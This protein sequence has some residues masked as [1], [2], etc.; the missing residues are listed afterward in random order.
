MRRPRLLGV[1][2]SLRNAR[3]GVGN[4]DLVRD[5]ARLPDRE[6]LDAWLGEQAALHLENF[7]EAGRREG[8][9]F[10]EI[11]RNLRKL[12]GRVGLSNSEVALAAGLWAA[13][14]AGVEVDHLSLAEHFDGRSDVAALREK[15][16]VADGLLV[17][18]PVYFGDRGS[19]AE[20]F[21]ELIGRD[22]VLASALR[23]R[24]YG[25]IAVGAKRNGGQETTLVYQM[26]DMLELGMLAV[27]ND[28]ETTSQYGGT[29]HAGDVGTM[30]ADAYGLDTSIGTGRRLAHVM[31]GL[32]AAGSLADAPRALFLVL[33]D[34]D[35][36]AA[37]TVGDLV[38][39]LGDRMRPTV[40][41][42]TRQHVRRCIAC[43]ICPTHIGP[44][45]EYRCI[46]KS[47]RD[48][49]R[50]LHPTLLHHDLL[51]PVVVSS[52]DRS[53]VIS[54]YQTF[55]ERTRYLRRGDYA[56][57]DQ[58]V[59]PMVLEEIGTTSTYLSRMCTSFIRHHT[60]LTAPALG[61]VRAGRVLDIGHLADRLTAAVQQAAR[62][63]VARLASAEAEARQYN[64]VGYVLSAHKEM[65]DQRLDRRAEMVASR[66][67]RLEREAQER[68]VGGARGEGEV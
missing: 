57:S 45:E 10:I 40:L 2:A 50:E 6:S 63:A 48:D 55:V 39:R 17:S 65:E 21:I 36:L 1:A 37:R 62:L 3:W 9:D 20:S 42:L 16:A 14:Q 22:D 11:N 12:S 53:A 7:I 35:G 31:L 68:L 32:G 24:P 47:K 56:L 25:G 4:R 23:G 41:D 26:L 58:L 66:H 49:L 34:Q 28:S 67:R 18:G 27:G 5:L 44:D 59:M 52:R 43:D 38:E 19:L 61:P 30:H 51:V 13:G 15:V 29:G 33:R 54:S 46:I 60:V 64:P 8:R